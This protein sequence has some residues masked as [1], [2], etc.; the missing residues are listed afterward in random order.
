MFWGKFYLKNLE[1]FS[2]YKIKKL[3]RYDKSCDVLIEHIFVKFKQ[4][5]FNFNKIIVFSYNLSQLRSNLFGKITV[6]SYYFLLCTNY[7]CL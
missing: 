4:I 6:I 7:N 3:S 2:L 5:V 1:S